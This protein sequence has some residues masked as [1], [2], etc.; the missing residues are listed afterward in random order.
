MKSNQMMFTVEQMVAQNLPQLANKP[1]LAKPTKAML[2]YL[3]HEQQCNDIAL[4]HQHL[5]GVDFVEQVLGSFNFSYSVPNNEIE[6]IPIDGRVVIY[7]NHPIGSLDALALIKLISKVRPDIKV[8]ANELLM[9]IK[10]LHSILLPVRNM[11]GGTPKQHLDKIHQHLKSEGALLIFP[12]GEVSRLRP[13]GVTDLLWQTGFVKMAKAC[14]APLL[15]MFVDAK[16][17]ATF[18]GASMLYKPLATLLLVK[19]MFRQVNQVM[20]V[21]IGKLIA[22][23]TIANNDFPLKTQVTLLKNHLYR[24]GKNRPPLFSTQNA[25][26]HPESRTCLQ[27]ELQLCEPLGHTSDNKVIYLY[28][29]KQSSAIMREIGRLREIAFRAVGEGTGKRRDIDKYDND[30]WHLVLWDKDDLE[31]VGAYRFASAQHIHRQVSDNGLYSETLFTYH[32]NF[33]PYFEQGL[34]L[35]RSFVQPK[36]WGRR[37]LE[38]LWQ[39]IG[40]FLAKH[41]QYRYLFGPVTISNNYPETAKELLIHFYQSQFPSQVELAKSHN[42]YFITDER[43]HQLHRLFNGNNYA[44]NFKI[45]KRTLANM[46]VSVPTL[47]KQYGELCEEQGVQF[48]DFGIDTEFGDCIDGLVL[49]DIHQLKPHKAQKYLGFTP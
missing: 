24:I 39:G 31:I 38:Y 2:R 46:G 25:V 47:F 14:N 33:A 10:P 7:A 17:S 13:S 44:D 42:A 22:K 9:A 32:A 45:L 20:P 18:Y 12:S 30:Y 8:V 6:N 16:N 1:W 4:Q 43:S 37:S 48:I 15:P 29:H 27:Q 28:Q 36:Y 26:A 5:T 3:L 11:T 49:V 41:P 23:E 40:A 35:G 34:E 21:R 19:E